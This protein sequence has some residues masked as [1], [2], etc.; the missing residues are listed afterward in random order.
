MEEGEDA[1]SQCE[2]LVEGAAWLRL[3]SSSR[4]ARVGSPR[5]ALAGVSLCWQHEEKAQRYGEL[6][7]TEGRTLVIDREWVDAWSRKIVG[8]RVVANVTHLDR[9]KQ[10]RR[11]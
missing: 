10:D 4:C 7:L 6:E 2:A 8:V 9:A 11:R 1:W 5:P 3:G